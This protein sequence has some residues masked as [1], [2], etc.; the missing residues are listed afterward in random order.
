VARLSPALANFSV[1]LFDSLASGLRAIALVA[2]STLRLA[3]M[4]FHRRTAMPS[5]LF[6]RNLL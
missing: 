1:P 2:N 3:R 6:A 4:I 5:T